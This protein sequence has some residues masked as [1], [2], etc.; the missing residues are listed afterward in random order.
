MA[1]AQYLNAGS[2]LAHQWTE[3]N[4]FDF[5]T[6]IVT[7]ANA[8]IFF[9]TEL[10]S[11][12][13]FINVAMRYPNGLFIMAELLRFLLE[14]LRPLAA[15]ALK[16]KFN[17]PEILV[18]D[19]M[20][21]VQGRMDKVRAGTN[22]PH[23]DLV[24]FFIDSGRRKMM[25]SAHRIVQ[26]IL[27][28]WFAS[29]HQPALTMVSILEGLDAQLETLRCIR[30]DG[31]NTATHI[32]HLS[33]LDSFL[34]ESARLH[35]SDSITARGEA[36]K[37]FTFNDSTRLEKNDAAC[38]PLEALM[39]DGRHYADAQHF[40]AYRHMDKEAG[41]SRSRF[42]EPS[43]NFPLWGLGRHACPGRYYSARLL[44]LMVAHLV[45]EYD[46]EMAGQADRQAR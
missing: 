8:V 35:L 21:L 38:I 1:T 10:A 26:V 36:I 28:V 13:A 11:D 3:V 15:K 44:K 2:H 16:K 6:G 12:S 39:Q 5:A 29:V 23:R 22:Q 43:L 33:L 19:L 32:D 14:S 9:G 42:S 30:E 7:H 41:T 25:W 20:P 4:S 34:K 17:S 40:D 18:S 31:E 46:I 27:G 24:Q 45:S 37:P